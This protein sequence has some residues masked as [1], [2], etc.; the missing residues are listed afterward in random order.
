MEHQKII[1]LKKETELSK[2]VYK[3]TQLKK[4]HHEIRLKV[5]K[6]AFVY[7]DSDKIL[8]DYHFPATTPFFVNYNKMSTPGPVPKHCI[9]FSYIPSKLLWVRSEL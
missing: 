4:F 2:N 9:R 6:Y 1:K 8:V 5:Y 3:N 7:V